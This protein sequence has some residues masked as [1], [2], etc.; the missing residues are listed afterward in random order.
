MSNLGGQNTAHNQRTD[1]EHQSNARRH[2]RSEDRN[3]S[4][5]GNELCSTQLPHLTEPCQVLLS[6]L[7]AMGFRP[8]GELQAIGLTSC[9]PREGV[10]TLAGNLALT[11]ARQTMASTLIVD[12]NVTHPGVHRLFGV[13]ASPGYSDVICGKVAPEECVQ[14]GSDGRPSIVAAGSNS[15]INDIQADP[16]RLLDSWRR[17]F[18]FVIFDLPN[19][20]NHSGT[21]MLTAALDGIL[22]VL[23][24][25]RASELEVQKSLAELKKDGANV[26]GIAFNKHLEQLPSWA[27]GFFQ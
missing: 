6:R 20:A 10:T 12:A 4:R 14:E 9:N 11:V 15:R 26:L 16:H 24:A 17:T 7:V 18:D 5:V 2:S 3:G 27:T 23:E 13:S 21:S 25:E 19:M 1:N 8:G 22:F